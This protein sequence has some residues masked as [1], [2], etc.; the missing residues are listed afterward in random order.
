MRLETTAGGDELAVSRNVSRTGLLMAT[1]TR[2]EVG[3]PVTVTYR[4][5]PEGEEER[6]IQGRIVRF[7]SNQDDPEG[8]W[9]YMVAIE[10]LEPLPTNP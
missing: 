8:L 3:A 1:A 2:L 4:E 6:T 7:E 5:E 9:P 10:F